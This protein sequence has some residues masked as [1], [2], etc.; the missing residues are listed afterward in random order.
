MNNDEWVDLLVEARVNDKPSPVCAHQMQGVDLDAA[1]MA[2]AGLV[3]RISAP[4]SGFKGALTNQ[5]AQTA[6]GIDTPVSGVLLEGMLLPARRL[7]TTPLTPASLS[8]TLAPPTPPSARC[9]PR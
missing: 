1:Y 4:I 9:S 3:D 2:Q 6:M 7:S 5:A 8:M